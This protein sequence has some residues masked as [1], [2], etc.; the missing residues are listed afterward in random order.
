M[1]TPTRLRPKRKKVMFMA[2][3]VS[4]RKKPDE[5]RA[6]ELARESGAPEL[7]VGY[8]ARIGRGGLLTPRRRY[9]SQ[10][11]HVAGEP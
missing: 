6:S 4:E 10:G 9:P 5:V 7:L 8:L 3:A 11:G 1:K 2:T